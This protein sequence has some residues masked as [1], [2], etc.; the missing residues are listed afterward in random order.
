MLLKVDY[1]LTY[2]TCGK[3][4][5][6]IN[7]DTFEIKEIIEEEEYIEYF[8]ELLEDISLNRTYIK[9]NN[10]SSYIGEASTVY[11]WKVLKVEEIEE[12]E[13][14]LTINTNKKFFFEPDEIGEYFLKQFP[15]IDI[16]KIKNAYTTSVPFQNNITYLLSFES[17]QK[18]EENYSEELV[19]TK[20]QIIN[21]VFK[22]SNKEINEF[23]KIIYKNKEIEDIFQEVIEQKIEELDEF[24]LKLLQEKQK[25]TFPIGRLKQTIEKITIII[26]NEEIKKRIV[27]KG[28]I[29]IEFLFEQM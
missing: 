18:I 29:D 13:Y 8:D 26:P 15:L 16:G 21:Y 24:N 4:R 19:K 6:V 22:K 27:K 25:S 20:E 11:N 28:K 14:F 12:K 1:E 9:K 23:Q 2:F 10:F 5:K 17:S 3:K 7:N